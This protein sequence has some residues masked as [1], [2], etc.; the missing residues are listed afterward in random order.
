[1]MATFYLPCWHCVPFWPVSGGLS[2]AILIASPGQ[3]QPYYPDLVDF[4][5]FLV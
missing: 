5:A 3:A 4:A 2:C 1:M